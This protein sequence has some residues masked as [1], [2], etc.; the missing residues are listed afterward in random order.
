MKRQTTEP[1]WRVRPT[2]AWEK[3]YANQVTITRAED[4]FWLELQTAERFGLE[5]LFPMRSVFGPLVDSVAV[6]LVV[7]K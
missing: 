3:V 2:P 4:Y 5:Y 7:A 6:T 1:A